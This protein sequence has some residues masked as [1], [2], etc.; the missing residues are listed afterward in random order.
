MTLSHTKGHAMTL[1]GSTSVRVGR[2]FVPGGLMA[3]ILST[4]LLLG[5][6]PASAADVSAL[7]KKLDRS[8]WEIV[9]DE[10]TARL[11][12][13]IAT[14]QE[15]AAL[16]DIL[17]SSQQMADLAQAYEAEDYEKIQEISTKYLAENL[18]AAVAARFGEE[19]RLYRSA[20]LLKDDRNRDLAK[21]LTAAALN[22]NPDSAKTAIKDYLTAHAKERFDKLQADGE[23][24]L[25]DTLRS[26]IPG[27][28]KL[29]SYGYDPVEIYIQQVKDFRDFTAATRLRFNEAVL[30][31][32]AELYWKVRDGAG[33]GAALERLQIYDSAQGKADL[34]CGSTPG[35]TTTLGNWVEWI[36]KLGS[37]AGVRAEYDLTHEDI[38][39]LAEEYEKLSHV[40][41]RNIEFA[42]WVKEQLLT[43]VKG[44]ARSFRNAIGE[45]QERVAK[46]RHSEMGNLMAAVEAEIGKLDRNEPDQPK[47][48]GPGNADKPV[49]G[50]E[51]EDGRSGGVAD[52]GTEGKGEDE[53][54]PE[55][56][57]VQCDKLTALVASARRASAGESGTLVPALNAALA[58]AREE[59]NCGAD[60]FAVA[61]SARE[62]L[63]KISALGNRL[64]AAIRSCDIDALPSLKSEAASL[65]SAVFDNELTLLQTARTGVSQFK[66]GRATFDGGK[67]SAAK[68]PLRRA[69]SAFNELPSGACQTYADRAQAGLD[70]ID[71]VLAQQAIVNRAIDACDVD[72][73]RTI[74]ASY[75]GRTFRFFT[76][77]VARIKVAL[78]K[79][80]KEDR[81]IAE[82]KFCDEMRGRVDAASADFMANRLKV[83]R[84]EL[85]ALD[86]EL[87]PSNTKRCAELNTRVGRGLGYLERIQA[88]YDRF[89]RAE[90]ACD[91][92]ALSELVDYYNGKS[93]P[94]YKKAAVRGR[95]VIE[96]C[97]DQPL[98]E[99]EAIADCRRQIEAKGKVYA[100]TDYSLD[101]SYTCHSCEKGEV[102]NGVACVP[103][104]V[105][106]PRVQPQPQGRCTLTKVRC[107]PRK[108]TSIDPHLDQHYQRCLAAQRLAVQQFQA[109]RRGQQQAKPRVQPQPRA[110]QRTAPPAPCNPVDPNYANC[111]RSQGLSVPRGNYPR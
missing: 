43:T 2:V 25:K 54:E 18:G 48:E 44:R 45:E 6:Y 107:H 20:Q 110:A 63:Q 100:A 88:E 29:A 70:Q 109:C 79:C 89:S 14:E 78:P 40:K 81:I 103:E 31:C 99:E 28:E 96:G 106:Q 108:N 91:V 53:K 67:Y 64:Q 86:K 22:L 105:A 62:R 50:Q 69:L 3:L 4:F 11:P 26:V 97:Q 39:A 75:K 35:P 111:R 23:K 77:S 101:G 90:S 49:A 8:E 36:T 83:A 32:Q 94:W 80:E 21:K 47:D 7:I 33:R 72:D 52:K 59:G 16:Q 17:K 27:G 55:K 9:Q 19:S 15:Q 84:R 71:K 24:L 34:K 68:A 12:G 66:K 104:G 93:H 92:D 58:A 56:V 74:L 61:D 42:E 102:S 60:V 1:G 37:G 73:L 65:G 76:E 10:V 30:N 87:T 95:G 5:G 85:R 38:A 82:G 98:T 41:K 13:L 46:Q 51:G 57:T